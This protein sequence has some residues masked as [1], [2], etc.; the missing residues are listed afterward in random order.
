MKANVSFNNRLI[1]VKQ[2]FIKIHI[3]F[4]NIFTNVF[5]ARFRYRCVP[6]TVPNIQTR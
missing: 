2:V 5:K 6:I 3:Q 1:R 4:P